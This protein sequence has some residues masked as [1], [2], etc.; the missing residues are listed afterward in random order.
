MSSKKPTVST[1]YIVNGGAQCEGEGCTYRFSPGRPS[2]IVD[3]DQLCRVCYH[4]YLDQDV[5]R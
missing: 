1:D 2:Y 5:V 3:G 4:S